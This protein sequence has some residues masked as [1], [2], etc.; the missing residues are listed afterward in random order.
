MTNYIDQLQDE[1]DNF[2]IESSIKLMF[3]LYYDLDMRKSAFELARKYYNR[4]IFFS[5]MPLIWDVLSEW[6][7]R[8]QTSPLFASRASNKDYYDK[9]QSH[10][11][12]IFKYIVKI[13][14][15]DQISSYALSMLGYLETDESVKLD[16]YKQASNENN[17]F[18]HYNMGVICRNSNKYDD[19]ILYHLK[20]MKLC[21]NGSSFEISEIIKHHYVCISNENKKLIL[22]EFIKLA[23]PSPDS[24]RTIKTILF[25]EKIEWNTLYHKFSARCCL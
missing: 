2:N 17:E 25:N 10:C 16:Y 24:Q 4:H 8:K 19:S 13:E 23:T 3:K 18:G 14:S 21:N 20:A 15:N 9:I 5:V 12:N 1:S 11:I 7:Q 22:D 6:I